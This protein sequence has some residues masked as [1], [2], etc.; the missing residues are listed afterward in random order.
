MEAVAAAAAAAARPAPTTDT[1]DKENVDP[2]PAFPPGREAT[3]FVT[4]TGG[5][6]TIKSETVRPCPPS[7]D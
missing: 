2:E 7:A 5:G 1:D 4:G 3:L 6:V